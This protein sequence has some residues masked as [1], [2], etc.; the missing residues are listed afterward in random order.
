MEILKHEN[1]TREFGKPENWDDSVNGECQTLPIVDVK[2]DA[3]NAMVSC[4]KPTDAELEALKNG[5]FI[6]LWIYGEQHPVVALAVNGVNY[7]R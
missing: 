5:S 1:T 4:W 2:T 6:E 3:G 7:G